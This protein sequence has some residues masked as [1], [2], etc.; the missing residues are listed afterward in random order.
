MQSQ[1][2]AVVNLVV[3][4]LNEAGT[5]FEK[6]QEEAASNLLNA[7]QRKSIREALFTGFRKGEIQYKESFQAK[8]DDDAKL[9]S[10]VSGLLLNHLRK[11]KELNG[12]VT[13]KPKN[14]G[15][16]TGSQNPEIKELKK[17][18][19]CDLTDEQRE[20]VQSEID[21]KLQ[22]IQAEK[23]KVTVDADKLPEHLRHL[24]S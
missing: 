8:V 3:A 7:D 2:N 18:L 1:K 19:A 6:F 4:T 12:N 14:P 24:V 20:Q 17:L 10:Y 5:D 9:N 15:S 23:A 11:A 13:Y 21:S 22:A 16:R